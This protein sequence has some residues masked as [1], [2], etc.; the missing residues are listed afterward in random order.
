MYGNIATSSRR[1]TRRVLPVAAA[2]SLVAASLHGLAGS[3]TNAAPPAAPAS[4]VA[5][6]APQQTEHAINVGGAAGFNSAWSQVVG[7]DDRRPTEAEIEQMRDLISAELE[8]GAWNVTAGLYYL[9]AG[10]A[11][12]EEVIEVLEPA[13]EWRTNF[14]HHMRSENNEV[15]EATE[16][17]IEIGEETGMVPVVAH[18]KV[19]G[20][21]NWGKSDEMISL[22]EQANDRGTYMAAEQYPYVTSQASL[23]NQVPP[24]VQ[25]GGRDD[26]LDRFQ[27]P[28]LRPQI[29]DEIEELM[30]S[31][32]GGPEDVFFPSRG[33]SLADVMA[34][35]DLGAGETTIEILMEE[36]PTTQYTFGQDGPDDDFGKFFQH[37]LVAV[38]SDGG[39]STSV[40]QHPRRFG[41]FPRA[42]GHYARD[43]GYLSLEE[44]VR[45]TTGL[46][47]TMLGMVDRGFLAP[48][49][50]ADVA[51]FDPDEIIDNAGF[52]VPRD[53]EEQY[54]DGVE[55]V[56]VNGR[57]AL[58]DGEVTGVQAGERLER[59]GS[60][61]SRPMTGPDPVSASVS[62]RLEGDD[63]R[64]ATIAFQATGQGSESSGKLVFNDREQGIT[65]RSVDLGMLQV[66][67]DWASITGRGQVAGERDE[68]AF[69]LILDEE[70]PLQEG[71]TTVTVDI[72]GAEPFEGVL[73]AGSRTVEVAADTA[74]NVPADATRT[75][76]S[77]QDSPADVIIRSGYVVDGT[78]EPGYVADVEIRDGHIMRIGDLSG[79]SA[80]T[81]IDA[82]GLA[83]AP[84][85][86]NM[87]GGSGQNA[88]PA[89]ESGLM[90]GITFEKGGP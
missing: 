53:P 68:R 17:T 42:I 57:L 12:T 65:F 87:N 7:P 25:D 58:H 84:G 29:I 24:W 27:D 36:N 20:G 15:V 2:V 71:E 60:M 55:H 41:T 1:L 78:G 72:A 45:K 44:S 77:G 66:A 86:I 38:A 14:Q 59:G 61:I 63:G 43:R 49:M 47:A 18:I 83:V 35:L 51:V 33:E 75:Q 80:E 69:E 6:S 5:A 40:T 62:G 11:T 22:I 73:T 48:G 8:E 85:F 21:P 30:V 79:A 54:S 50:K 4:D 19:M 81:E 70:N 37:P 56:L 52:E 16:E 46:P 76:S 82:T 23:T 31:R 26:M 39:V 89:A 13:R 90:Q 10:F 74:G 9:P 67:D 34:E 88:L 3:P 64:M 32:V 28:E